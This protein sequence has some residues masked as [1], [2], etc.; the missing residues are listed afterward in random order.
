MNRQNAIQIASDF[1]RQNKIEGFATA[2]NGG[3]QAQ[4]YYDKAG[5]VW[6]IG[7]GTTHYPGGG[8]VHEGDVHTKEECI[9]YVVSELSNCDQEL[10]P[11]LQAPLSDNQYAALL[12]LAYNWGVY[13]VISSKLLQLINARASTAVIV[14]QWLVT[15]ITARGVPN[16]TLSKR[17]VWE[18]DLYTSGAVISF[19]KG[20]SILLLVGALAGISIYTYMLFKEKVIK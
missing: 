13:G 10:F 11:H 17:R 6:T 3:A 1:V 18:S 14:G 2:I 20:A 16:S 4:A 19:A 5:A 7:Y 8:A 9:S 15:A 12:S